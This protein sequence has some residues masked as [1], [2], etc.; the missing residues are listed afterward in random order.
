M[1]DKFVKGMR[2]S[3]VVEREKTK[4]VKRRRQAWIS[5]SLLRTEVG[6]ERGSG[7][8]RQQEATCVVQFSFLVSLVCEAIT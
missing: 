1:S 2:V 5:K 8:A 6:V 3:N 4:C 7:T